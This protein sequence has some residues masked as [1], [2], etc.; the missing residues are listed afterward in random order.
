LRPHALRGEIRVQAFSASAVNLQKGRPVFL[1]GELRTVERARP[2]RD[3]WI[4]KLSG[5]GSRNDVEAVRG[6]LLETADA[7]VLRDDDESYFVHELIGLRVVTTS[8]AE[9]GRVVEVLQPGANDVYVVRG[10]RGETLVPA[11][12]E[13]IERIDVKAGEISI[14]P[15]PGMLDESK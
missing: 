7:D 12:G 11:I 1:A 15:L 2:D 8:G 14:T 13:V 4:V 3:H 9:L 5:L 10:E 6:E